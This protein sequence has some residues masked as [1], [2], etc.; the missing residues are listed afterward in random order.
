MIAAFVSA[1]QLTS[2]G[3]L[4]AWGAYSPDRALVDPCVS[5]TCKLTINA[6]HR[7]SVNLLLFS[8]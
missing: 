7:P 1:S 5:R 3:E 4:D 2:I 8:E 6:M